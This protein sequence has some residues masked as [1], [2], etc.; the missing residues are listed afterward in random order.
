MAAY[1]LP[2]GSSIRQKRRAVL[3]LWLEMNPAGGIYL[4]VFRF[5]LFGT[6]LGLFV[7]NFLL[8]H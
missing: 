8:N 1:R 4:F 5:V 3:F 2:H 7:P 6:L